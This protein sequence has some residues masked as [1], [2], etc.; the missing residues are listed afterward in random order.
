MTPG[1]SA[2]INDDAP[3]GN[4]GSQQIDAYQWNRCIHHA[5]N[6]QI[7]CQACAA[8]RELVNGESQMKVGPKIVV[9]S[10]VR[11]KPGNAEIEVHH[12][13]QTAVTNQTN[14]QEGS[15]LPEKEPPG[16]SVSTAAGKKLLCRHC[17]VVCPNVERCTSHQKACD[18]HPMIRIEK[19]MMGYRHDG[20]SHFRCL[21]C[22][23]VCTTDDRIKKHVLHKHCDDVKQVSGK[24]YVLKK[25]GVWC[26]VAKQDEWA[27]EIFENVKKITQMIEMLGGARNSFEFQIWEKC[28]WFANNF[29]NRDEFAS[30]KNTIME[31]NIKSLMERMN[32]VEEKLA[33]S[34]SRHDALENRV[35]EIEKIRNIQ[36]TISFGLSKQKISMY[37]HKIF[38]ANGRQLNKFNLHRDVTQHM[39]Y[40]VAANIFEKLDV[41]DADEMFVKNVSGEYNFIVLSVPRSGGNTNKKKNYNF[42]VMEPT[43]CA[44]HIKPRF[45]SKI[46]AIDINI[47]GV[48]NPKSL[49]RYL[50]ATV[51]NDIDKR[52]AAYYQNM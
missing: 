40:F 14:I 11:W 4:L 44:V 13:D 19:A 42:S 41:H 38:T 35:V 48:G 7:D 43:D 12:T 8:E 28:Q 9:L 6:F 18:H 49:Q 1:T 21:I 34:N 20:P 3:L 24:D 17:F 31:S 52:F 39:A 37:Q 26:I 10:E 2:I 32:K 5:D 25:R 47:R 29:A 27:K 23:L 30:Y 50:E 51:P 15:K 46:C 33:G 45:T 36:T 16:E 22:S